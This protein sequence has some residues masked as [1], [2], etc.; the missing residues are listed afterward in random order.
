MPWQPG[1][2][3]N[4][5]GRPPKGTA[6]ADALRASIRSAEV[7]AT[8]QDMA[9]SGDM[10]ACRILLDRVLPPLKASDTPAPVALPPDL[11][12][13]ATAVLQAIAGGLLTPDQ[14]QA[15][16]SVLA[17]LARV[18]EATELEARITALEAKK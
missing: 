17:S 7:L 11:T 1:E 13:A 18:K 6:T 3:G 5:K 16:A 8:V 2:S 15:V 12:E 9:L 10:V 4:A 14:G